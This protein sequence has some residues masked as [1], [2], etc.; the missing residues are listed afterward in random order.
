MKEKK[1]KEKNLEIEFMKGTNKTNV[2]SFC[3]LILLS[4]KN[5]N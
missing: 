2:T 3:Q 1:R 4:I 5:L